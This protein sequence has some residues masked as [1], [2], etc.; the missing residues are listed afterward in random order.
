MKE[1]QR[2]VKIIDKNASA[3]S[4]LINFQ[5]ESTLEY[6]LFHLLKNNSVDSDEAVAKVLYGS[7]KLTGSYRMLKSRFRRKL[8]NHLYFLDFAPDAFYSA[9]KVNYTCL[10]LLTEAQALLISSELKLALK[11]LEQAM[12]LAT[13]YENNEI[14]VLALEMICSI[15]RDLSKKRELD[16]RREE[17]LACYE[18]QVSEREG[19]WLYEKMLGGLKVVT[20]E[21]LSVLQD[22]PAALARMWELWKVSKSSKIFFWRHILQIAYLEQQGEYVEVV[23][24]IATTERL[25]K[26]KKVNTSWYNRKFNAFIE[27]YALLQSRQYERGLELAEKNIK[28][29][30]KY[31]ANWFGFMENYVLLAI[32]DQQYQLAENLLKDVIE[33]EHLRKL[34]DSSIE[35]WEL[36]RRYFVFL[37]EQVVGER[38]QALSFEITAKLLI[39]PNDK[40][41]FNLA[42]LVLDV[43]EKLSEGALDDLEVQAER[44][45][46]YTQKY[47]RGEKAE[48]PRLFMRLLLLAL[49]RQNARE[50]REQGQVLLEKLQAT[51]LPGDAFT[52]V[53]IV[54]Y[55]HLWEHVLQLLGQQ[56]RW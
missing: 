52:E 42:L 7:E 50:A 36:Y 15:N 35:R 12:V 13:K 2:L 4:P 26:E 53:E 34:S 21:K 56:G 30:E 24:A 23:N 28:L 44:V 33:G 37:E 18:V 9:N 3:S 41:G 49:T 14:K 16:K 22:F 20:S 31:T 17:L 27:V 55:E 40:S 11:V 45:R 6:K 5:D 47:L 25:V 46:K 19:F 32:H 10:S 54:P 8:Y 48:R 1:L 39:L 29:F 51:P 38:R 43:L